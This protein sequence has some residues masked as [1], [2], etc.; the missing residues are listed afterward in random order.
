MMDEMGLHFIYD[1]EYV[2][3]ALH[4]Y[5][6]ITD[7]PSDEDVEAYVV[8]V[9]GIK[10]ALANIG[11]MELSEDARLLEIAGRDRNLFMIA[12][13]TPVLVHALESLV[14]KFKPAEAADGAAEMSP[15][16][17]ALLREKM[18]DIKDAAARFNISAIEGTANALREKSW[19]GAV[20]EAL[21]EIAVY[22]LRGEMRKVVAI[23]DGILENNPA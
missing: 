8:A 3:E 1:A 7:P 23:A 16:D 17:A 6:E 15:A 10:T 2:L 20:G 5:M 4:R 21:D 18:N 19:P 9:H 12:D 22:L 13:E 14:Q 11:E